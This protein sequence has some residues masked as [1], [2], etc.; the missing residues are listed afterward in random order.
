MKL[1]LGCGNRKIKGFINIDIQESPS[2]DLIAN[3]MELPYEGNSIDTIYSCCM[4]EH[5]GRNNNMEFF[6][7]TSWKDVLKYWY[8]LLKPGGEVYISVPNFEAVCK[9]YLNS[10]DISKILG[11]T[12]GGQKNEEDLHGMLYDYKLLSKELYTQGFSK[13]EK[14][15]WQEFE[16]F[17][18]EGYDDFSAS[19]IPHMDF[20]NGRLMMLNVKGIK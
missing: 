18:Q 9:E 2:V 16:P 11:I 1:H 15:K 14:Y 6:R 13:V 5:F 19:Y 4:L 20:K 12:I 7:N 8:K 10:G 3:I 17:K